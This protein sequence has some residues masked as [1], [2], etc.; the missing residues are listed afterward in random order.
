MGKLLPHA[1]RNI[2]AKTVTCVV[3]DPGFP[4]PTPHRNPIKLQESDPDP[5]GLDFD[6]AAVAHRK[7]VSTGNVVSAKQGLAE[8]D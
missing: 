5:S 1:E 8:I 3:L 2:H 4:I 7:K 6:S